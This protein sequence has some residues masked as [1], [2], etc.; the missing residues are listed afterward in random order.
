MRLKALVTATTHSTV[1]GNPTNQG[2]VVGSE[3]QRQIENAHSAGEEHRSGDR[4]HGKLQI[5][6]C[7]AEIVVD[8]ETKNQAGRNI[9]TEKRRGSESHR[10]GG[11]IRGRAPA[12]CSS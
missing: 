1:S 6:T 3:D 11:E 9:D 12:T 8:A 4:L 7:A 5:R 10:A 2:S